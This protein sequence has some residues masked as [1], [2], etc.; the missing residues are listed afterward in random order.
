MRIWI[1]TPE[2]FFLILAEDAAEARARCIDE[3]QVADIEQA[4]L[5]AHHLVWSGCF[6][7]GVARH[8][9]LRSERAH[10]QPHRRRA[11]SAVVEESDWTRVR[12]RTFFEVGRIKEA[13]GSGSIFR[14]V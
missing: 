13:C 5:V 7:L 4:I 14:L 12:R 1:K 9:A 8:H 11:R 2:G 10:M 6:V 3:N